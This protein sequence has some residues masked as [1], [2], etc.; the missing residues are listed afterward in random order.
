MDESF[1]LIVSN[2]VILKIRRNNRT[3]PLGM[4]TRYRFFG[5]VIEQ[6]AVDQES[7]TADNALQ[8]LREPPKNEAMFQTMIKSMSAGSH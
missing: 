6:T 8:K 7:N 2:H 5:N 1:L 3:F 4:L